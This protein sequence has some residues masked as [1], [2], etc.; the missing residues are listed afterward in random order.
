[1]LADV[2]CE[3]VGPYRLSS[4]LPHGWSNTIL[5]HYLAT[6][7]VRYVFFIFIDSPTLVPTIYTWVT[8]PEC[9]RFHHR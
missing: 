1:M 6:L 5:H 4:R 3:S 2:F 9:S 8:D 7:V